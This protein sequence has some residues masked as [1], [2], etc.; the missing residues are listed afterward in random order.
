MAFDVSRRSFLT[1]HDLHLFAGETLFDRVARVLCEAEC[2]PRKELYESWEVARRVRRRFRGGRVVDLACGHGLVAQLMMLLD[3]SS[4][5][6]LAIDRRLPPSA[7]FVAA[8]IVRAWPRLEGRVTLEERVVGDVALD[9][10]DVVVAAHACGALTDVVL[11]RAIAARARVA[12][13]PCCHDVDR[14]DRGGLEGWL[15]PAL[16]IDVTRAARLRANGYDVRTQSIPAT[17]TPKNR[18]LIGAPLQHR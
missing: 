9:E 6:A 3:D 12:V 4:P 16:A 17:V 1:R 7:S 14:S 5:R 15:D 18:L 10:D 13:L 11:E 8:A 2:L